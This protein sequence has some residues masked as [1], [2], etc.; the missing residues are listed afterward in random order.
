MPGTA[1]S[2]GPL[3]YPIHSFHD[4]SCLTGWRAPSSEST[5][6]PS[7]DGRNSALS[8]PAAGDG[9]AAAT[10]PSAATR[11]TDAVGFTGT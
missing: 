11:R 8:T 1:T 7:N 9:S 10:P 6:L 4:R 2:N 3:P 5:P